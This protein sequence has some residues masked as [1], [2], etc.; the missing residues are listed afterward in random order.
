M[1]P[2]VSVCIPAYNG[3]RY[4]K[5]CIDSILAQ[6]FTDFE[7]LII[8]DSSS[9]KT[10]E[11][12]QEYAKNDSRIK[13]F[14]NEKN[15]GLVGNWNRC[16][17]LAQGEWIKFVFQ[18]DLIVSNCLERMLQACDTECKIAFCRR[19]F[20]FEEGTSEKTKQI[21]NSLALPEKKYIPFNKHI[22][23]DTC[24]KSMLKYLGINFIGE[25]TVLMIRKSAFEQFG[26]FN[27]YLI[28]ICDLEMW[29]R[30]ASNVGITYIPET[31][32]YFRVHSGATTSN[33]HSQ[34]EYRMRMDK[35]VLLHEFLFN[36]AYE[37]LRTIQSHQWIL[38][39]L[40]RTLKKEAYFVWIIASRAKENPI[41]QNL[42][43]IQEWED[44]IAF[45]PYMKKI[46]DLNFLEK[47]YFMILRKI[48]HWHWQLTK[49]FE[50]QF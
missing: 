49:V 13:V 35:I 7:L 48:T 27:P 20:L 17:E 26:S 28:Q 42:R 16:I 33:N 40:L 25:P 46:M 31:L 32:A 4:L 29:I 37:N 18:D 43:I 5:E 15:L 34:R 38:G 12:A 1:K 8:D 41:N 24:C 21:Y 10:F 23:A 47:I 22:S 2:L 3:E 6:T 50:T 30:I 11:I 45:Y 44:L 19:S 14:K 36:P 9:D 39:N